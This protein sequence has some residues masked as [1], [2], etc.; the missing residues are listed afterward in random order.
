MKHLT[1]SGKIFALIF[2]SGFL[3]V[4][5]TVVS[6]F[7]L[8]HSQS[9]GSKTTNK[10]IEDNKE[11]F[12]LVTRT[13]EIQTSIQEL[14][15]E[16][17]PDKIEAILA[18]KDERIASA[19]TLVNQLSEKSPGLSEAFG[20]LSGI[21]KKIVDIMLLGDYAQ[22]Q[23]KFIEEYAP[24][25]EVL[26]KRINEA[27]MKNEMSAIET[28]ASLENTLKN[29]K[30]TEII[31]LVI[32][33]II[34]VFYGV[35]TTR[36]VVRSLKSTIFMLQSI[37]EGEGD[38]T[39]RLHFNRDDEIGEMA[40]WFNLFIEKLQEMV[41]HVKGISTRI[42]HSTTEIAS[43]S[44]DLSIR[45]NEQAASVTETSTTL[46]E[47]TAVVR[48]NHLNSEEVSNSIRK[49]ND[50]IRDRTT[51]MENVTSTMDEINQSGRKIN[52][53]IS[54]INDIS[55]QTNLLALNAAVEAARAGEAGR[56]FAVVASEVRILAQKT[57]ES[58][59]SIQ[60]IVRSNMDSTQRGM[61]LVNE[62]VTF[63]ASITKMMQNIVNHIEE[64]S[65]GSKEQMTGVEQIN[66]TIS[67][68]DQAINQN[69]A[70]VEK[71]AQTGQSMKS[72]AQELES[73]VSMF[74]S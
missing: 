72:Y 45:T 41:T 54:V 67:Q 31:I 46:E 65:H 17:D 25:A 36:N 23:Q 6:L 52:N 62:T 69:A 59:K 68:L 22:A 10:I 21:D 18:K 38:L 1:I 27:R 35:T 58:S 12:N 63:F 42:F 14:L 50:E 40:K 16:K 30:S 37:A 19:Q 53:I 33:V 47:F 7:L 15:R 73:H 51:L 28:L 70:L 57:A 13:N 8:S 3:L 56:G 4:G 9:T 34:F 11:A 64:I 24:A 20:N 2:L 29:I 66:L 39:Q 55:F 61:E 49:F 43:G 60:E 48:Q 71:F 44:D 74:K 32:L 5:S 26:F